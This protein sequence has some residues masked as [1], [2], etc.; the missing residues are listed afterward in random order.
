[1][2]KRLFSI[3]IIIAAFVL[4]FNFGSQNTAESRV[5]ENG[6]EVKEIGTISIVI[7]NGVTYAKVL[8]DA[9]LLE[10]DSLIDVLDRA[11]SSTGV[12]LTYQDY[13]GSMGVF[14]TS[15]DGRVN[16]SDKWWQYWVNGKY[17]DAGAS[18]YKPNPG[19]IVE[20]RL[21]GEMPR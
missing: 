21:T 11:S 6:A 18:S 7:N 15:I 19:D 20:F 12:E 17:A 5:V 8:A 1:M 9:V 13:G 4:G 14:I 3:A 2:I 16:A 10:D